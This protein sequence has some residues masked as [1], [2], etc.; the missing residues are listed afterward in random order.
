MINLSF[1]VRI[2]VALTRI[3]SGENQNSLY[4]L[5]LDTKIKIKHRLFFSYIHI[6]IV[7]IC[8]TRITN[9]VRDNM[10]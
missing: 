1:W 5:G 7:N 3:V 4:L 9:V 8:E 10:F 2:I 6:S